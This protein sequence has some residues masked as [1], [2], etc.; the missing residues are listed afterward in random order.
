MKTF[1][2]I[3]LLVTT[4]FPL[5][6]MDEKTIHVE[7]NMSANRSW[8]DYTSSQE[9]NLKKLLE[10]LSRSATGEQIIKEAQYKASR[11]GLTL[12]DVIRVGESSLTDTTLVRKFS[13]HSPEHV[14][15][16]SRS[17]VYINKSLAWDDALLDLA[18]EL[19]H[20]VYR[21]SFNPYSDAFNA[22]DFIKGT[23]E[24]NGG[25]VQAFL[26]ECRVLRELFSKTIQSRSNC[27]KIEDASG[28]LSFKKAV[29]L[30]YH[31]GSY[32]DGFNKQ[33]V[34]RE[35][36]SSFSDLKDEKINFISS[37]YGVPYPVAALMEYD[38]VVSKVCENDKK[39]LAYMQQGPKRGPASASDSQEKFVQNYSARCGQK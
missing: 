33:L 27:Q 26:T 16:E 21:E 34:K 12:Q 17:V 22:K 6:A 9:L 23:I 30:F 10:L 20:Y 18:H 37:A 35:I 24:G 28:Q 8:M 4:T 36:A 13:P 7:G 25:E 11:T 39:R 1:Y 3:I 19:T 38:L 29:E 5:F 14:I 2:T 31:V 15:Y 32:F